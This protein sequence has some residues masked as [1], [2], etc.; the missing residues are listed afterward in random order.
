M[1]ETGPA[2]SDRIV[3]LPVSLPGQESWPSGCGSARA[4]SPY[5]LSARAGTT[6]GSCSCLQAQSAAFALWMSRFKCTKNAALVILHHD[7]SS[8]SPVNRPKHDQSPDAAQCLLF[9]FMVGDCFLYAPCKR[10]KPF[11]HCPDFSSVIYCTT[12]GA[13]FSAARRCL[14]K[15]R[16]SERIS[17]EETFLCRRRVRACCD[18]SALALC[19]S[20][21]SV[22]QHRID[23]IGP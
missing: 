2:G 6:W 19:P 21:G 1:F 23:A 20:S 9:M 13:P 10:L 22:D 15:I 7:D 3:R 14:N 16:I 18:M 17:C 4:G 11:Y 8:K 5:S 12:T